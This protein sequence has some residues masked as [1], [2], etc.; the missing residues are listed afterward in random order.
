MSD[1]KLVKTI[2]ENNV[3]RHSFNQ[4]A[5]ETF[6]IDFE[7]WYQ[8]GYWEENYIP[9]CLVKD[10]QVISNASATISNM[11][12]DEK[13]YQT[14]QIGTVMTA[15]SHRG[16]GLSKILIQKIINDFKRKVDFIYLF[17]NET[18][19]DFYP[20]FG[21]KRV[22]ELSIELE[23][24]K[25]QLKNIPLEPVSFSE[26]RT[27]IEKFASLRN[28]SQLNTY[29]VTSRGLTLFYYG[30]IF[31]KEIYY[32][33][34]LDCYVLFEIDGQELH[35]L[36]C[37]SEKAVDLEEVLSYL[38]LSNVRKL[39]CHFSPYNQ[40]IIRRSEEIAVDDDALFVLGVE[41]KDIAQF[42]LPLIN[43]A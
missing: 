19:L 31:S 41:P 43:H 40:K 20:K 14:V 32:I 13:E 37:L 8:A 11:V 34:D 30:T 2:K 25:I 17:A 29:L 38:P 21:F 6:E 22:D 36:D 5:E 26:H 4:L 7:E 28:N 39:H 3:L 18:V 33:K 23:M 16:Q 42:K 9:Y 35:L 15:E 27:Q 24:D 10:N 12:V 1:Y